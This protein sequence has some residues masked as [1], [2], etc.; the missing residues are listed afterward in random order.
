[1]IASFAHRG[2]KR[3]FETG[4]TSGID[5]NHATRLRR[6]LDVLSAATKAQDM[7]LPGWRLHALKGD[8]KGTWAVD[9]SAQ[10]RL[11]FEFRDGNAHVVD[12]EQYH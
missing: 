5:P 7:A 1:M 8:R 10:W 9:V 12:Y 2:L 6:Q 4:S 3:L 11:T